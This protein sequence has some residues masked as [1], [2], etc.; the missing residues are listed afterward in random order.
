[1]G[2]IARIDVGTVRKSVGA[3]H[4]VAEHSLVERKVFN[5]LLKNAYPELRT[6]NRHKISIS[7]LA[8][9]IGTTSNNLDV[10]KDAI[11]GL[12]SKPVQWNA[13]EDGESEWAAT[14]GLASAKVS[15]GICTYEYSTVLIE[16]LADPEIYS[17]IDL[18]V[19]QMFT[20]RFAL[21]VY[22]NCQRFLAVGSTGWWDL[23]LFRRIAGATSDSHASFKFLRRDVIDMAIREINEVSDI[24][25]SVEYKKVGRAVSDLRFK[26]KPNRKGRLFLGEPNEEERR[27]AAYQ[28]LTA[29]GL[30]DKAALKAIELYDEAYLYEKIILTRRMIKEGKVNDVGAYLAAAIRDDFSLVPEAQVDLDAVAKIQARKA[31]EAEE[32]RVAELSIAREKKQRRGL[33]ER[34]EAVLSL[35]S[36]A[37][38]L[39]EQQAFAKSLTSAHRNLFETQGFGVLPMD[40]L[41]GL[42]ERLGA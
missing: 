19:Q 1:M 25:I 2:A 34:I 13:L 29:L 42:A 41:S 39:E 12:M 36:D 33:I 30:S 20:S 38:R 26:V 5:F 10:I 14:T 6:A 22:E 40:R 23:D 3:I 9:G 32:D 31:S 35:M 27:K 21:N 11:L 8:K 28:D 15:R 4:I 18:R 17:L 16:R 37:E 7:D 24:E